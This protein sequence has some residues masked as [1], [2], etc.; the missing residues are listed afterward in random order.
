MQIKKILYIT[1]DFFLKNSSAAIRNNSLV[2]GLTICGVDV[3]VITI[4]WSPARKSDFFEKENNGNVYFIDLSKTKKIVQNRFN[5]KNLAFKS[6]LKRHIATIL[7]FPDTLKSFAKNINKLD[8]DLMS[9]D[10]M[11]TSS[12][13]KSSHF[14]GLQIKKRFKDLKWLQIW[15]DPWVD[16]FDT[17]YLHKFFALYYEAILI[18]FAEKVFYVSE[19]T[20]EKLKKRYPQYTE[21]IDF[22]PRGYYSP[23]YKT[24]KN[25]CDKISLLY[26]G[27]LN[28]G[29]DIVS[30]AE[31]IEEFNKNNNR[32]IELL[33]YS[34]PKWGKKLSIFDS[35]KFF[36]AVDYDKMLKVMK[37]VDGLVFLDNPL[38]DDS[39]QIPGKL[40]DYFGTN[41]PI[42]CLF[43]KNNKI[44]IKLKERKRCLVLL[45]KKDD[46]LKSLCAFIKLTAENIEIDMT[47]S[48]N[49]IANKLLS[50]L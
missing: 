50:K 15:G 19:L 27:T 16:N 6:W 44:A 20:T 32:K 35:I 36:S 13:K 34:D 41:L 17:P 9:Y 1:T 48:P 4:R 40:F 39:G 31:A 45:N 3:D 8:L 47:Y 10:L 23:V 2:K 21:K 42:L 11:I 25:G 12:E 18:K 5:I 29:R 14:A 7:Y 28:Y 38:A 43:S 26:P 24:Q 33:I 30:L 46:I 49:A 37:E 22:L